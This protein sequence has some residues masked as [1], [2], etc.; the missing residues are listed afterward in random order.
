MT[1]ASGG[2]PSCPRA[3]LPIHGCERAARANRNYVQI[4][5]RT[6][7]AIAFAVVPVCHLLKEGLLLFPALQAVDRTISEH[8]HARRVI[9]WHEGGGPVD[10]DRVERIGV[11]LEKSPHL[12]D[13]GLIGHR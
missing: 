5:E 4:G 7:T 9:E 1:A 2:S 6:T 11:G 8:R 3:Q 10:R 12:L 13:Q